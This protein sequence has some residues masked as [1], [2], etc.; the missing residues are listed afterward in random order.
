MGVK[1]DKELA[2]QRSGSYTFRIQGSPHHQIGPALPTSGEPPKFS[3]IYIYDSERELQNRNSIFPELN[4]DTLPNLQQLMHEINPFVDQ[5]KT[6]VQLA[7]EQNTL[8]NSSSIGIERMSEVKMVFR[9]EGAHDKRRYSRPT[10]SSEIGAI[11]IGGDGSSGSR[12]T[13]SRDIVVHLRYNGSLSRINELN[14]F[15]D[16]LHYVLLYPEGSASWNI[17]SKSISTPENEGSRVSAMD[18]YS[19]HL[20]VRLNNGNLLHLF[21]KLFHQYIVDMYAKNGAIKAFIHILQSK[22]VTC[23]DV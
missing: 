9:A 4:R 15:Y 10:T 17:N 3:Q 20:M 14:Q 22:A 5:Y 23:R 13:T 1:L 18:Y 7:E 11:I 21:G 19:F 6:M 8:D 16:P 2:N 12:T